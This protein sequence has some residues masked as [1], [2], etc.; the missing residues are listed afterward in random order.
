MKKIL[1]ILSI[2]IAHSLS[3]QITL[4]EC[5]ESGLLN[6]ANIKS[7]NLELLLANLKSIESEAKFLPQISLAYDY[8]YNP[9]IASQIVPVGQFNPIATNETRAIKFGANWQQSAGITLYQP[10]FDFAIK[11]RIKE[12]KLNE[13]FSSI[14]LKKAEADLTFE[15]IKT[16]SKIVSFGFQV[17][18]AV[19]D[20][21]RS[22]QS[23]TIIN[24]RFKEGRTLK[25][26]LNNSLVNHNAN[27][28]NY[29]KASASLVNE[30]IYL[31]YLT[32]IK[33]E[34]ILDEK[35]SVIPN[36]LYSE[37]SATKMIQ[38]DLIPDFQ[39]LN[40]KQLLI[41]QQIKTEQA[42]NSP[43]IGFQGYL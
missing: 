35:Y 20:T 4:K 9:I 16:Y 42:K 12:S 7:S 26:E 40:A 1:F 27:L 22:F 31:H 33:I 37:G 18:E 13:S 14:D 32:N 24:T 39:R 30:K 10:I 3:A 28:I 38:F 36:A 41:N 21:I 25:T 34:K 15:I 2:F 19:S 23:Y 5:I 29:R 17:D 43:T 6:R 11:S 8:R